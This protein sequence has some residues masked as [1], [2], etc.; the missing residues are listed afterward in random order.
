MEDRNIELKMK[1]KSKKPKRKLT[2]ECQDRLF[3]KT[4]TTSSKKSSIFNTLLSLY[5]SDSRQMKEL[6]INDIILFNYWFEMPADVKSKN[7][8]NYS[9]SRNVKIL[10]EQ[11]YHD[12]CVEFCEKL[13]VLYKIEHPD[14]KD[15]KRANIMY[16]FW[17]NLPENDTKTDDKTFQ[18][19]REII[20]VLENFYFQKISV[21]CK[22]FQDRFGFEIDN[23]KDKNG[24]I[25]MTKEIRLFKFWKNEIVSEPHVNLNATGKSQPQQSFISNYSRKAND[26]RKLKKID[27]ECDENII[28]LI[29]EYFKDKEY[30][31]NIRVST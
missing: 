2:K 20:K 13:E 7:K 16:E 31:Q 3:P 5:L 18:N 8:L 1:Q 17:K 29:D 27:F 10:L 25:I 11:A 28:F 15:Y 22:M 24:K 6:E 23:C 26:T 12:K 9:S 30:R 4:D 14:H 21:L 19:P